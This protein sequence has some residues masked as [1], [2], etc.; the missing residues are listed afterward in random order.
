MGKLAV[1]DYQN[2]DQLKLKNSP[3]TH[4]FKKAVNETPPNHPQVSMANLLLALWIPQDRHPKHP[5]LM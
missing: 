5:D 1:L 2:V 4:E 3:T